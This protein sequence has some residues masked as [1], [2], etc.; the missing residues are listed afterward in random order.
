MLKSAEQTAHSWRIIQMEHFQ[1][2]LNASAAGGGGCWGT[3]NKGNMVSSMWI[4]LQPKHGGAAKVELEVVPP[5]FWKWVSS[6]LQ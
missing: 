5:E 6:T 2:P 1:L 4:L 3:Q